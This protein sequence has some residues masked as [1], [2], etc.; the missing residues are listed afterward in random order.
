MT[1]EPLAI[2]R[3][4]GGPR[5]GARRTG[6]GCG[7]VC[8]FVGVVRATHQGRRV[9]HLGLRSLRAAGAENVRAHPR[10]NRERVAGRARWRSITGS[11]VSA[12]ARRASRSRRRRRIGRRR[13][14]CA[15]TRSSASS[16]SRRSG[17]TSSSKTATRGWKARTADPAD[18]DARQQ[19]R[20]RHARDA[21]S[22]SPG[23]AS[24]PARV[25]GRATSPPAPRSRTCGGARGG[26]IRRSRRSRS[27]VSCAVNAD[28]ARMRTPVREGDDVAF[29]PPV[30]GG[31]PAVS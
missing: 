28:F 4:G 11:A 20:E 15:A 21:S 19:A 16:R 14:R 23:C 3:A 31:A 2:E 5:A 7:A 22:S 13:S 29:L 26:I 10:G 18:E 17:S 25:S 1:S 27:R 6:E 12:S 8:T 30:S 9:R 24:W